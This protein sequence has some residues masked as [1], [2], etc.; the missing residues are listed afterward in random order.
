MPSKDDRLVSMQNCWI[1][2]NVS[3]SGE[4]RLKK[5]DLV[6]RYGKGPYIG[7][8]ALIHSGRDEKMRPLQGP[9]SK[10]LKEN[11][12][13]KT[14]NSTFTQP[15]DNAYEQFISWI[16]SNAQSINQHR[17]VDFEKIYGVEWQTRQLNLF[18][19]FAK[20]FGCQLVS[21]QRQVPED[22]IDLLS[23]THFETGLYVTFSINED[24]FLLSPEA[25]H[26]GIHPLMEWKDQHTN[27][28][29]GYFGGHYFRWLNMHYFYKYS[30]QEPI[31][32]P[33]RADSQFVYLGWHAPLTPE[34][35]EQLLKL[36][37]GFEN[38]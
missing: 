37:K 7:D 27:E 17:V 10:L 31:G 14:C 5:S 8:D 33:W 29:Q 24:H 13:C 32:S 21:S 12:L 36:N 16:D 19:Y 23:K 9:D 18:K 26:V 38:S 1:C 15:F 2:G 30:I 34:Q 6:R 22:V 3:D 35:R 25:Q 28:P 4:H 20:S 11:S